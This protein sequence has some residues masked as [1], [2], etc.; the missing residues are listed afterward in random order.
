MYPLRNSPPTDVSGI[1]RT[2]MRIDFFK[3]SIIDSTI[4]LN[5][6]FS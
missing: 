3:H 1:A 2:T 4:Q 5:M 6:C